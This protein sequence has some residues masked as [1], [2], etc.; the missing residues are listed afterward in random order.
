MNKKVQEILDFW[1]KNTPPKKRFQKHEGFDQEIRDKFLKDYNDRLIKISNKVKKESSTSIFITQ[2]VPQGHYLEELLI[3][4]NQQTIKF[5]K[6]ETK[7]RC[8]EWHF[9]LSMLTANKAFL[10][11]GCD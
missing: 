4:V 10:F 6:F 2:Q 7:F 3:M 8:V 5:C 9:S 11:S 1:F